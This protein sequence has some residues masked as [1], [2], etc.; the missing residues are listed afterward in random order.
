MTR[1]AVA[2]PAWM[3]VSRDIAFA[4]LDAAVVADTRDRHAMGRDRRSD[5][6][7]VTPLDVA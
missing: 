2:S 5:L 7:P 1:R 6:G 4:D 3:T